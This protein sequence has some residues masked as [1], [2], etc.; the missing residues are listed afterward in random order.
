MEVGRR[1]GKVILYGHWLTKRRWSRDEDLRE[2]RRTRN[3]AQ[4]VVMNA[5]TKFGKELGKR[6]LGNTRAD[7]KAGYVNDDVIKAISI[8]E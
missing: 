8:A 7:R 6:C 1:C 3:E 5:K 4:K 2:Y